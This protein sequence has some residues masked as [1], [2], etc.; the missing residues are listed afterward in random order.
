MVLG[1]QDYGLRGLWI[2]GPAGI[3]KSKKAREITG[4]FN[5]DPYPKTMNKWWDGYQG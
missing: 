1:S 5:G 2:Y 3:G 4:D